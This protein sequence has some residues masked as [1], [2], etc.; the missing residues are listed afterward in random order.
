[1]P[2][3]PPER[4]FAGAASPDLERCHEFGLVEES[5]TAL[6]RR[7]K[8]GADGVAP[9]ALGKPIL[10]KSILLGFTVDSISANSTSASPW[11]D[12]GSHR[13]FS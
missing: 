8:T 6:G 3:S 10:P 7:A 13:C 9:H 2:G 11:A 1:M 4:G 5:P 12:R